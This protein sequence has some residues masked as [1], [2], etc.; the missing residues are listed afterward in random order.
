MNTN[1]F[2]GAGL[3]NEFFTAIAVY[4]YWRGATLHNC[5]IIK[6]YSRYSGDIAGPVL[7]F[8]MASIFAMSALLPVKRK[9]YCTAS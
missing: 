5:T 7:P 3:L 1:Y 2:A 8:W 4:K 6:L 9:P